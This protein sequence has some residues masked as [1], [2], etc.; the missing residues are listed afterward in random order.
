MQAHALDLAA[1]AI[2]LESALLRHLDGADAEPLG[3]AVEHSAG[4]HVSDAGRIYIRCLGRPEFRARHGD[5]EVRLA[6]GVHIVAVAASHR[7]VFGIHYLHLESQSGIQRT[8]RAHSHIEHRIAIL[9][10]AGPDERLP[11]VDPVVARGDELHWAVDACAGIPARALFQVLQMHLEQV[12]A[13]LHQRGDIHAEGI[14]AVGP[15]AG[16]LPV[17]VNLR[18]GHRAVEQQF[19]ML[20]ALGD[21]DGSAVVALADPGQ[22][23]ASARLLGSLGLAV[24]LDGHTLQVPL[25]VER[26]GYRPVVRHAHRLP[27]L[28]VATELPVVFQCCFLSRRLRRGSHRSRQQHCQ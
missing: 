13:R 4:L 12:L 11:R 1:D 15:L 20:A 2:E 24:L 17:E 8:A 27:R 18:L 16:E 10:L 26:P 9:H 19:G 28:L 3:G 25:L 23:A 6:R 22:G 14:V 7:A 21:G 5:G